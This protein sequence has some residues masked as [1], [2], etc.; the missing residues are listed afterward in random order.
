M[1]DDDGR[2]LSTFKGSG[3]KLKVVPGRRVTPSRA[4]TRQLGLP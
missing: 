3:N 2:L 4:F 1:E